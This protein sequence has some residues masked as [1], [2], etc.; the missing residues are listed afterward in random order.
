M[1]RLS[2]FVHLRRRAAISVASAAGIAVASVAGVAVAKSFTL[3]VAK[4]A[5]VADS[6]TMTTTHEPIIVDSGGFAVYYLTGESIHHPLCTSM[7]CLAVWPPVKVSSA[8]QLSKAPGITGKLGTWRRDGFLQVTLNGHPL[9]TFAPDHQK[10]VADGQAIN[11][12]GGTWFVVPPS[13]A[14]K[15]AS[16]PAT[17]TK[18]STSTTPTTTTTPTSPGYAS[19]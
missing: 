17:T 9:Y 7:V 15:G 14:F 2:D 10:H 8:K 13:A 11:S 6:V 18:P 19:Y 3:Q 16:R 1:P 4:G 12:F 5:K